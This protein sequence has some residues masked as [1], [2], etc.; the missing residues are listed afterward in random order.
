MHEGLK[1]AATGAFAATVWALQ[2]PLDRRLFSAD[3]SD[4]AV[5]GKAV[6]RGAGWRPLG[7]GLHLLNGALFGVALTHRPR[8]FRAGPLRLA[9][10]AALVEHL[11]LYPL[12]FIV[13]RYHPARGERG[14]APVLGSR[15]GFALATWRHLVFGFVLG[16]L[17][18][19][20]AKPR[21]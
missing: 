11:C 6:T 1:A 18:R 17:N 5:L 7:F 10:T 14:V 8:S 9:L 20:S 2:E 15:R 3:Y 21:G 19:R 13:D 12:G 16:A 4:V